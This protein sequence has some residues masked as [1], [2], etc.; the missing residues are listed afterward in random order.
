LVISRLFSRF[1]A[2]SL[3]TACRLA[4][5]WT[6]IIDLTWRTVTFCGPPFFLFI[7]TR[8]FTRQK[9]NL[10][11]DAAGRLLALACAC[12][13][14]SIA[15]TKIACF[16]SPQKTTV[17]AA[18]F[19]LPPLGVPAPLPPPLL[20]AGD[21]AAEAEAAAAAARSACRSPRIAAVAWGIGTETCS[22]LTSIVTSCGWVV[23][24]CLVSPCCLAQS[25]FRTPNGNHVWSTQ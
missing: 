10:H 9:T 24:R 17:P 8:P 2:S 11:R 5:A 15:L 12:C 18:A 19:I 14:V 7:N 6:L 20:G 3:R 22:P 1:V 23:M 25:R 4:R 16:P 13:Y 21:A